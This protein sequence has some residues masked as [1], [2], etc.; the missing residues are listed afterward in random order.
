MSTNYEIN[1]LKRKIRK[2][3]N[4]INKLKKILYIKI[5]DDFLIVENCYIHKNTDNFKKL[6]KI[7]KIGEDKNE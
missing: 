2:Y 7:L 1:K 4:N 6:V 5:S 3:E